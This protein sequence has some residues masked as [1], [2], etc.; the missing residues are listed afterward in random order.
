MKGGSACH[1]CGRCSA[2][3]GAVTLARRSPNH[4]IVHVAGLRDQAGGDR[5]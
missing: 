5:C 3:R 1:M 2:F 4:E